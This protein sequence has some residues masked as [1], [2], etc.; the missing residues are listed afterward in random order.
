MAAHMGLMALHPVQTAALM[1]H[2]PVVLKGRVEVQLQV[3]QAQPV[4]MAIPTLHRVAAEAV[5]V[6]VQVL[7]TET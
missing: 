6:Q 2:W 4:R 3:K 7:Q 5:A 1:A